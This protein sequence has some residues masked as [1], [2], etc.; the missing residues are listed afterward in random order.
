VEAGFAGA[1][2]SGGVGTTTAGGVTGRT[3]SARA[4]G[5]PTA[6]PQAAMTRIRVG[7]VT[8]TR[9]GNY[10]VFGAVYGVIGREILP[11]A[12]PREYIRIVAAREETIVDH[13]PLV[14]AIAGR[15]ANRGERR[16]DLV[17]VGALA[18]VRAVDRSDPARPDELRGYLACCVEG[19]IRRHLRDRAAPVRLPRGVREAD[20]RLRRARA[21][22]AAALGRE[23][24]AAE[25]A[26][27]AGLT[28]AEAAR[29]DPAATARRPLE[30]QDWDGEAS[31]PD[32]SALARAL[33]A[34]A[35]RVL[36]ARERRIVLLRFFLDRSQAEIGEALGLSQAHVSRLLDGATAK[37]RRALQPPALYESRRSATLDGDGSRPGA[38]AGGR[39]AVPALDRGGR[40]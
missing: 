21:E 12:F 7:F 13:L 27:Q 26:R 19:E 29:A 4:A 10:P 28:A 6:S 3:S 31:A 23:P 32:D 40:R 8:I 34:R 15:F 25:V 22:L 30:L 18:L 37:M 24:T 14:E 9:D 39:G 20:L 1:G 35:A 33:V 16:E 38:G 17:Q 5:A 36:D 2:G 11:I